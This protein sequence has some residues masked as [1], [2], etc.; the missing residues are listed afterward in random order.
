MFGITTKS[1]V[2]LAR[3]HLVVVG[4]RAIRIG[5]AASG[6]A[7]RAAGAPA[8]GR[9]RRDARPHD[10]LGRRA[11]AAAPLQPLR[12]VAV[13]RGIAAR[14]TRDESA[15]AVNRRGDGDADGLQH[16]EVRHARVEPAEMPRAGE[17]AHVKVRGH[18]LVAGQRFEVIGTRERPRALH[19]RRPIRRAHVEVDGHALPRARPRAEQRE[20]LVAVLGAA[21]LLFGTLFAFRLAHA[22]GKRRRPVLAVPVVAEVVARLARPEERVRGRERGNRPGARFGDDDAIAGLERD[23]RLVRRAPEMVVLPEIGDAAP[24]HARRVVNRQARES[25][26]VFVRDR[27]LVGLRDDF[28][29]DEIRAAIHRELETA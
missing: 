6:A 23:R 2:G 16:L 17:Q 12:I 10:V 13:I 28:L 29:A 18:H 24:Q 5:V 9:R 22:K 26:V 8:P 1:R 3:R 25:R 27:R 7:A 15:A 20:V 11:Q 4:L 19:G 21:P 14:L